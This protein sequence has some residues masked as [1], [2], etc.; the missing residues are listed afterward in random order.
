MSVVLEQLAFD[1][2]ALTRAPYPGPRVGFHVGPLT[3]AMVEQIE[4]EA[5]RSYGNFGLLVGFPHIWSEKQLGSNSATPGHIVKTFWADLGC[6]GYGEGHSRGRDRPCLCVGGLVDRVICECG[7]CSPVAND[8]GP[9]VEAW[10]D[11]AWP[12]W[13]AL[14]VIPES[15]RPQAGG[16][17]TKSKGAMAWVVEHY[18][19]NWQKQG[20]PII[21]ERTSP[22]TRH[23]PG[24]SPWGGYD[25]SSTAL[26]ALVEVAA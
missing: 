12:G 6:K 2:D 5:R 8:E 21:T 16:I 9:V 3:V 24:Y 25:I 7:W 20:A 17:N 18:P 10:H 13:R 19:L 11:H 23:V 26:G 1:F 4:E 15:V 14:P 22:G